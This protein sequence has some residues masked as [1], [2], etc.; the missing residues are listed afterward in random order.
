MCPIPLK[1][2]RQFFGQATL[3][4]VS[5]GIPLAR[6]DA[7]EA[8]IKILNVSTISHQA[9]SYQGWPTISLRSNGALV[10]VWSGGREA[11]VCPFG[12]VQYMCSRN[13][14]DSWSWPR[15]ILD[16]GLDDRDAGI[17]ETQEGTLLVS[18]F[19]SLAYE[20]IL[21][22]AR[23]SGDWDTGRI[24]RWV[25]AHRRLSREDRDHELGQWMIRSEDGGKTWSGKY[26]SI[27]NSPHGP[28]QLAS[29]RL[30][31]AGKELWTGN[32]RVGLSESTDDGKSWQWLSDIPTRDGD[33]PSDYHELHAVEM[34]DRR[35]IVHI[36]NHNANHTNE[37][38]QCESSDGGRSWTKP[39]SIGVWGLPSHLLRLSDGR[40]LM[41]YGH[42]RPPFGNQARVSVDG[43]Q[44]SSPMSISEDGISGDLGYP[45]TVEMRDGTFVTVWYELLENSSNAVLRQARWQLDG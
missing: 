38:L 8:S 28:I 31:Y 10:V 7:N 21:K 42:R 25:A 15:V 12:Q 45:S 33:D 3:L 13:G 24:E 16:S 18:T 5:L 23:E 9:G 41:T 34:L 14:G 35:I 11:H 27:V 22:R 43:R 4:S 32:R 6:G 30:I 36:R 19:S 26:D 1:N 44:W 20:P 40:V 37:T 2:R 17:L 39:R 29:G